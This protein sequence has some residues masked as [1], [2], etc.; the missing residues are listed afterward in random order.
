MEEDIHSYTLV[1]NLGLY[2][3]QYWKSGWRLQ[4]PPSENTFGKKR[5]GELGLILPVISYLRYVKK[6]VDG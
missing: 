5:S 3:L 2:D 6:E 1:V 4:Q